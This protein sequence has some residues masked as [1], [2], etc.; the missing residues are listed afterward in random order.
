MSHPGQPTQTK[1]P[2]AARGR[3][4]P[5]VQG[6]PDPW[7]VEWGHDEFGVYQTF[8]VG[9]VVQRLRWVPAGTFFMGSPESEVGRWDDEQLY[10]VTLTHGFWMGET[11][12]TQALWEAVMGHNPSQFKHADRP[13]ETVSWK[14]C[15][16]FLEA[17][18]RR[19]PGLHARLPTEAEWEYACRGGTT[20]ATWAGDLKPGEEW[21]RA[22]ALEDIAWYDK[23]SQV[24]GTQPVKGKRPNPLGLFDML[25]N[26]LEWC[27]DWFAEQYDLDTV[28]DPTGPPSGAGRVLRGGSWGSIARDVR[29]ADRNALDPAVGDDGVGFRLVRG[30]LK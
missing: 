19:V 11:P 14:D 15:Q 4:H 20:A 8:Q 22:A 1:S 23:N 30:P 10:Q 24:N 29:A 12:C 13:V 9:E 25:G 6:I 7:A 21:G 5:L 26:V 17:L 27:S 16:N 2:R 18:E 28:V 3:W